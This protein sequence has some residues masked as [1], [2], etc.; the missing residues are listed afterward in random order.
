VPFTG[1]ERSW[2]GPLAAFGY[3]VGAPDAASPLAERQ[4]IIVIGNVLTGRYPSDGDGDRLAARWRILCL[5]ALAAFVLLGAAA[6]SAGTLP[7][8]VSI[9]RELLTE[10]DSPVRLLARLVNHGGKWYVLLPASLLVFAFSSLAR[11]HWWLWAGVLIG[12]ALV[13]HATKFL[14]GRPR[15]SGSSLGYPSG[16]T[17]AAATFAI[18]LVYLMSRERLHPAVRLA[19]QIAAVVAMLLVGWAR[20]VLHAH[21]PTDVLGGFLLGTGCAAAAAWWEMRR[22]ARRRRAPAAPGSR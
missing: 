21:W 4:A 7:G 9:R 5:L 19:I 14:V 13:E 20:V 11:R 17:T 22:D 1:P 16:H 3:N 10:D 2:D 18:L 8:D 15:P 12:S 6:F